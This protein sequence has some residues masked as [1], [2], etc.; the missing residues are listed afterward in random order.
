VLTE[1]ELAEVLAHLP[2]WAHWPSGSPRLIALE[3]LG[4]LSRAGWKVVPLAH[5]EGRPA[6]LSLTQ[7]GTGID[8]LPD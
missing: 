4:A 5:Q 7:A 3:F 6:V 8:D 2:S 1:R